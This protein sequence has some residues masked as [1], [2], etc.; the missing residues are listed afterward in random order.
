MAISYNI[1]TDLEL[2]DLQRRLDAHATYVDGLWELWGAR[3]DLGPFH[4]EIMEEYGIYESFK[5]YAFTRHS[6][7]NR[8]Q[9]KEKLMQFYESLPGRKLLR[10]EDVLIDYKDPGT[11]REP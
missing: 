1:H 9:A 10:L 6:K 5:T 11:H 7:E 4:E 2:D 3:D 8:V